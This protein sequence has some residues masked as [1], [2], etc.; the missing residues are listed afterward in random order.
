MTRAWAAFAFLV[1]AGCAPRPGDEP[2][3]LPGTPAAQRAIWAEVRALCAERGL[4]PGFV[5]ALVKVESGFDPHA[6][7]GDSRGLLQLKPSVWRSV[8][9]APYSTAVW[10]WR[11]NLRAGADYLAALKGK[12]VARG[13][14]SYRLLWAEF[15]YG[16]AYVEARG[17]DME[18]IRR[19]SDPVSFKLYSGEF[20]PVGPPK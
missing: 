4:E 3:E 13:H 11:A 9:D 15:H 6:R 12:M 5:Y 14:F 8:S 1:A 18:R 7:R 10:D 17:F 19:P 2:A 16:Y 20:N